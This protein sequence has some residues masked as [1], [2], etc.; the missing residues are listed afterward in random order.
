MT[1][2]GRLV[3]GVCVGL[4]LLLAV[5]AA[6][7][8]NADAPEG[9]TTAATAD[10]ASFHVVT[11][12]ETLYSLARRY[13]VSVRRLMAWNDLDDASALQTGQRLRVR[14]PDGAAASTERTTAPLADT[15]GRLAPPPDTL[16]RA[17]AGGLTVG[18]TRAGGGLPPALR[19]SI[20][21]R[22]A[23]GNRAFSPQA[24][25]AHPV[26]AGDTFVGLAARYGTSSD[27]LRALNGGVTGP[28]S[29]GR[30][31]RLP[32]RFV[33]A[34]HVVARGETLYSLAG[35]YGVSVRALMAAN[36]LD[37][38]TLKVG[39]ALRLPGAR[40]ATPA[41]PGTLPAASATGPVAVYPQAFAGRVMASGAAYDPEAF[42]VSHPSLPFGTVVLLTRTPE[43]DDDGR[44]HTFAVVADRGP[45]DDR[46]LADVSA[47]VADALA[48]GDLTGDPA[49]D[50]A[51]AWRVVP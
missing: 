27:T 45:L 14:P 40:L 15:T 6:S 48:L 28:L 46:F 44:L 1:D 29:P 8:Q 16:R 2:A 51:V 33:V 19:D 22:L 12:G 17:S 7:A 10:T 37:D 49:Q 9:D 13:G 11:A 42:V 35:R 43:D 4:V 30:Y 41:P 47:A 26:A 5:P 3:W 50:P 38:A 32:P 23:V 39:Q 31:V 36:D 18:T 34:R 24:Y 21:A 20:P 25:G